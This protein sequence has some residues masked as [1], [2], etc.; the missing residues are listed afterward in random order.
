VYETVDRV[1]E[2]GHDPRRFATD[3]LERLRDLIVLD[4]VPDANAK[5]LHR[6]P[7]DRGERMTDQAARLGTA[8][9]SR[10]ADIVHTGLIEMRG[11]TSPG[12]CS[13]SCRPG[14]CCLGAADGVA[15]LQRLERMER[16]L[17]VSGG[18]VEARSAGRGRPAGGRS[19]RRR[20]GSAGREAPARRRRSGGAGGSAGGAPG[21]GGAVGAPR[22]AGGE[23]GSRTGDRAT[24]RRSRRSRPDEP[25]PLARAAAVHAGRRAGCRRRTAD[26]AGGARQRQAPPP[27]RATPC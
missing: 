4:A 22:R 17:S 8:T 15:L 14:C 3:L 9:L 10:M 18:A 13:S 23:R 27:H 5:G 21:T 11:T 20:S 1:V 6:L 7:P 19:G 2:A 25:D 16:R 12:C 24:P 26:L